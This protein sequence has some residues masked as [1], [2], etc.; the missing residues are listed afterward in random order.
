MQSPAPGNPITNTRLIEYWAIN[1][2]TTTN[3]Q[4]SFEGNQ[5]QHPKA[6]SKIPNYPTVLVYS[7]SLGN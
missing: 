4:L 7:V 5:T 1:W 6:F 3:K 2:G